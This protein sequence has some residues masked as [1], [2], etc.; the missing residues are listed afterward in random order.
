MLVRSQICGNEREKSPVDWIPL[1]RKI[2]QKAN[3]PNAPRHPMP[4]AI[5]VALQMPYSVGTP[6]TDK[7]RPPTEAL[8][9][10][11]ES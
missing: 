1:K 9:I 4:M 2:P 3:P 5:Q 10:K 11:L 6:F 8:P 7:S